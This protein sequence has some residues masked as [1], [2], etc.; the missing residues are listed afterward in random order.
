LRTS[1]KNNLTID[2]HAALEPLERILE[3]ATC[4][5]VK[6]SSIACAL[7]Y[8][9]KAMEGSQP[10][11]ASTYW[12]SLTSKAWCYLTRE[13]RPRFKLFDFRS[14]AWDSLL[15]IFNISRSTLQEVTNH[16]TESDVF[17]F[18]HIMQHQF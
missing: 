7:T 5:D 11:H 14:V 13:R 16:Q 8:L 18:F 12:H 4:L 1:S 15:K 2:N 10:S 17:H 3:N 9:P 6:G